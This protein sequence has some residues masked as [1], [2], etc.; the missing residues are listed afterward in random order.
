MGSVRRQRGCDP[1]P[2]SS[3]KISLEPSLFQRAECQ[4]EKFGSE[5]AA[6]RFGLAGLRM[7]SRMPTRV[8][9]P[10]ARPI[11]GNAEMSWQPLTGCAAAPSPCRL[12]TARPFILP[13]SGS[14]KIRGAVD[15]LCR[16][17][18]RQR[19]LDD[20]DG[21]RAPCWGHRRRPTSSRAAPQASGWPRSPR[22]RDRRSPCH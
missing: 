18:M 15:Y 16:L 9:A 17:R 12:P 4:N 5:M 10:A 22:G 8:Q 7:S 13:V 19:H 14:E 6:T 21:C 1:P 11:S 20:D 2:H 3:S